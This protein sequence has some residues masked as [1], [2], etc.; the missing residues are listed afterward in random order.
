MDSSANHGEE[1]RI[2][3]VSSVATTTL[4]TPPS[5]LE[6]SP[7]TPEYFVVGTYHLK[8]NGAGDPENV[9]ESDDE[10]SVAARQHRSGSLLIFRLQGDCL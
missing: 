1:E 2:P 6:F 9:P 10:G 8:K 7:V 3:S 4:E 5:C